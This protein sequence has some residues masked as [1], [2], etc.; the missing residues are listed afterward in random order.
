MIQAELRVIGG[1]HEGK[2]IPLA[3]GKFLVGRERDCHLRPN[4]EMISRHHCVFTTDDYTVRLRDLGS[5]NGTIVN[6]QP[7]RGEVV[8]NAGDVIKIGKLTFEMMIGAPVPAGAPDESQSPDVMPGL[9]PD[10]AHLGGGDTQFEIRTDAAAIAG[11]DTTVMVPSGA[12]TNYDQP[13]FDPNAA[14]DPNVA[15]GQGGE[16]DPNSTLDPNATLSPGYGIPQGDW[17]AAGGYPY[18]GYG[19]PVPGFPQFPM[20]AAYPPGYPQPGYGQPAYPQ[21]GFPQPGY[22]QGGYPQ[23]GYPQ[24]GYPQAY[25]QPGYPA[26]QMPYPGYPQP[27]YGQPPAP[28][29]PQAAPAAPAQAGGRQPVAIPPTRLPDPE[30]TG[31]AA[32]VAPVAPSGATPPAGATAEVKPSQSAADIIK[33]YRQRR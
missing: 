27:G 25:P 6:D 13:A 5:T 3:V 31:A 17:Q 10:T 21:Q 28:A 14:Y 30:S 2:A 23:P 11:S 29:A 8:L 15:Y 22:P 1:K 18:P 24:G 32:P 16:Y 26:Q 9:N 12:D 7:I 4:S 33:A 20:Q 19:Q